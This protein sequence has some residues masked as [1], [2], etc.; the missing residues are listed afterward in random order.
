MSFVLPKPKSMTADEVVL[1]RADWEEVVATLEDLLE[2]AEDLLLP[3]G[4]C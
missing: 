4:W 1:A 3:P 2:D